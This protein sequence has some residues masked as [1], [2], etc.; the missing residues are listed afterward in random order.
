MIVAWGVTPIYKLYSYVLFQMVW[1]LFPFGLKMGIRLW[2]FG[3]ELGI[4]FKGTTGMFE[5]ICRPNE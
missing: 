2:P 3:L 5:R 4:V 1:F